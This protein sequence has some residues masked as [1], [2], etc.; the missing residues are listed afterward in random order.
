MGQARNILLALTV[1]VLARLLNFVTFQL[2]LATIMVGR[3]VTLH[4]CIRIFFGSTLAACFSDESRALWL[5]G[6]FLGRLLPD[7][8]V[9]SRHLLLPNLSFLFLRSGLSVETDTGWFSHCLELVV[10]TTVC[11]C[12]FHMNN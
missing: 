5:T 8:C 7:S 3:V 1:T 9:N 11:L 12:S 10:K 4:F 2:R 6:I